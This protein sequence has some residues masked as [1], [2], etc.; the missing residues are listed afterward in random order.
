M[1][2][3]GRTF[4]VLRRLA[5]QV[6][7]AADDTVRAITGS[8]LASWQDLTP[9]WQAAIT[10]IVDEYARTGTWPAAWQIARVEAV[11]RAADRTRRTLGVLQ[12]GAETANAAA[13]VTAGR[14][15]VAAEPLLIASQ[16]RG[17]SVADMTVPATASAETAR[18]RRIGDLH[19]VINTDTAGLLPRAL[20][21]VPA[22][23]RAVIGRILFG[24]LQAAFDAPLIRAVTVARTE[25]VDAARTMAQL[26]DAANPRLVSGWAWIC[27]CDR[28]SCV[29]CWAMHGRQFP[30][31]QPGPEGHGGCRCQRLPVAGDI[32]V[33]SAE[34]RFRR[35]PRRDQL[36]I[37][38]PGR[39]AL[40]RSGQVD[41]V[42][43]AVRRSNT[44]W[45]DSHVPR[46]VADL[47]RLAARRAT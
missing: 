21:P 15:A 39:D 26:V 47:K 38:G 37:L 23:D 1:P 41:W 20:Q 33:P 28:R 17:L 30:T 32:T 29:A 46:P 45:R 35:L 3:P 10:A 27:Q 16:I 4:T 24:R 42:D 44:G 25:P 6:G 9:A 18:R 22:T 31:A 13:A 2:I 14:A 5:R 8:W 36:T 19:Q 11:A 34:R 7:G 43:L 12:A 40:F